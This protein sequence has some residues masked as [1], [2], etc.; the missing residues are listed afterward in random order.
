[1]KKSSI[2]LC[3]LLPL[4]AVACTQSAPPAYLITGTVNGQAEMAYL[5]RFVNKEHPVMDS[6]AVV[7]GK[8]Q[9]QGSIGLPEFYRISLSPGNQYY[10]FFLENSE[11]TAHIDRESRRNSKVSG[12]AAD[13]VYREYL[14][15][16][17]IEAMIAK[18]PKSSALAYCL[19]RM[20]TYDQSPEILRSQIALFDTLVINQSVYIKGVQDLIAVYERVLPG[21]PYIE[22]AL[23]DP[24]GKVHKLS[25]M[26]GNYILLDFWAAWCGPCRQ[27]NPNLVEAYK[28]YHPKGFQIYAVSLDHSKEDW[29][30]AIADDKLPWTHVSDLVYWQC[31]PAADYGAR[32]IPTNF[33]IDPNG[34]IVAKNIRGEELQKKLQEVYAAKR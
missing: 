7:D 19:Y 1:M 34:N 15:S 4:L 22:I 23:P 30:K 6:C 31:A 10:E 5:Q 18:Y 33:L 20:H 2:V 17:N 12:S 9:F 11:I 16:S 26:L 8:F 25:D 21:K 29:V 27:E 13:S 28:K 24:D 3:A 32:A 14:Q